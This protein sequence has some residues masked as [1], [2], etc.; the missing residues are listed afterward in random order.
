MEKIIGFIGGER[1]A[2]VFL[3]GFKN[4][5]IHFKKII[6]LEPDEKNF[7]KL[8]KYSIQSVEFKNN[9]KDFSNCNLIFLAVHPPVLL[10]CVK[11]LKS[12]LDESQIVISLAPKIK[13]E[14]I[15]NALDGFENV[16]RLI[17][18]ANSIV[19]FGLNPLT[20]S[21]RMGK[22]KREEVIEVL[23]NLGKCFEVKEEK[24]EAYAMISG[25]GPTYF[26]FQIEN[27]KKLAISYGMEEEE[28]KEAISIMLDGSLKTLFNS[29]LSKEEVFDLIPSK[30]LAEYEEKIISFYNEKL[31]LIYEKIKT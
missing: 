9:Y 23:K 31:N 18:N 5:G 3:Y 8:E 1:I 25:M 7:K 28:A 24:L 2:R 14:K 10:E 29:P 26:W 27:L 13:I 16:A 6:V 30:P 15:K 22:N 19:N 4:K 20:F 11:N 12:H 17:P 21:E